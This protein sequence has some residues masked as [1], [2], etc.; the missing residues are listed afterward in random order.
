MKGRFPV[1][2]L[3]V[4]IIAF[5]LIGAGC[6]GTKKEEFWDTSRTGKKTVVGKAKMDSQETQ[7]VEAEATTG[8]EVSFS[9]D[10][11]P[12]FEEHCLKCHQG[13]SAKADVDLS[14]VS[15]ILR[16]QIVVPGRPQESSLVK[17]ARGQRVTGTTRSMTGSSSRSPEGEGISI[18]STY[19]HTALVRQQVTLIEK[20]IKAGCPNN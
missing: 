13:M 3:G 19:Q 8:E 14:A 17:I 1:L 18:A 16:G 10:L 12:I 5:W 20:W 2:W 7:A 6:A 9:E 11:K 15:G 4:I